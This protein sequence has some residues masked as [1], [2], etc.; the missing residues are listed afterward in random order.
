MKIN[1]HRRQV[2]KGMGIS[3]A[4]PL[5][6]G[7]RTEARAATTRKRFIGVYFPN[8][9]A[10]PGTAN[11]EWTFAEGLKPIETA[12]LKANTIVFRGL[13]S[14]FKGIDPHW[15]NCAGFM[16]CEPIQ[17]GNAGVAACAK[18]FD[19]HVAD[20]FPSPIR[21]LEIGGLY[22]HK[23]MLNDHPGYSH[24]YMNRISWQTKDK[25]LSPI[26]DPSKLF[27][28]IFAAGAGG[29]A[30]PAAAALIKFT[31]ARKKSILD[32]LYKDATRLTARLPSTYAPVLESYM[33]TVR[34]LETKIGNPTTVDCKNAP[35][36]PTGTWTDP[37][38]NYVQRFK[39][40]HEMIVLAMQCGST[41]AA[42]IMYGPSVS[43]GIKFTE[44]LGSGG[45]HHQYAHNNGNASA[46]ARLK[47]ITPIQ[48]GL[49]ADL[50]GKLKTANLLEETFVVYGSDMSDGNAHRT[51]NLP[52]LLFGAGADIKFGQEIGSTTTARPL[53]DLYMDLAS[54]MGISSI[55]SYGSGECLNTGTPL[56]LTV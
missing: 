48:V 39:L 11:G 28:S 5:L 7:V 36:K 18:S 25:F 3:L 1:L 16:S 53:S 42:S 4:L 47:K 12:G 35:A 21:S 52:F 27:D 46:I 22:Y 37:N 49:V 44:A 50:V 15:Q 23:H 32:H 56:G 8:G 13:H 51:T 33:S 10:M 40:M 30:D 34:E 6:P 20:A 43:D 2:L 54:L 19:Q 38:V 17:L 29:K 14:G 31:H 55:K 45:G 26:A 24:D 9:A 41:N